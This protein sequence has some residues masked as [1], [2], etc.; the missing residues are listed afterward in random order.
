MSIDLLPFK[1]LA[2]GTQGAPVA[3]PAEGQTLTLQLKAVPGVMS[4]R[5]ALR[6]PVAML[7]DTV[8]LRVAMP[9]Q[10][11]FTFTRD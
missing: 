8:R 11:A 10:E 5:I 9:V 4:G 7:P 2:H 3:A 6:E 1:A